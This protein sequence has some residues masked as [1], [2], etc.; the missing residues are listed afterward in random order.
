M[1]LE[2]GLQIWEALSR[3]GLEA[4]RKSCLPGYDVEL[5]RELKK[6]LYP[7]ATHSLDWELRNASP[8][9]E[10]FL[11]VFFS[12]LKPFSQML[13]DVLRMFEEAGARRSDE[14]LRIA[15]NF[16][17]ASKELALTL[18]E[19]REVEAFF[20]RITKPVVERLWDSNTLSLLTDDVLQVLKSF[21]LS[22][23]TY[24]TS[25]VR[26]RHVHQWIREN[27]RPNWLPFPGF[28]K[29]GDEE[30]DKRIGMAEGL[31]H[32][33]IEEILKLGK[34]YREFESR[35]LEM[36][37]DDRKRVKGDERADINDDEKPRRSFIHAAHDFWPN[38]F[39]E[40]VCL[41]IESVNDLVDK[42]KISA[43]RL[44]AGINTGFDR[45]PR[46]ERTLISI[47][48]DL[49]ELINLPIWKKRH[50]LYAVWVATRI[51]DALNDFSWE[52][53]PDGDT[54]RFPFAGVELATLRSNDGGT[55]IF[56]TEK[57][58]PLKDGRA[59]GR[60]HIQPD[61]RIMTIPSHRDESTSLVV[62][63]KQYR[64]WSRSNFG[65]ALDDYA[66]GCPNASVVLVNYGP[67]DPGILDLV[68]HSRRNRTFLL[69]NFKPKGEEALA[70]FRDMVRGAY[71]TLL[72][73]RIM[74]AV[75]LE[76]TWG[77]MFHDLDLHLFI[78][79]NGIDPDQHIGFG[80]T[81]GSLVELPWAKWAE[82]I[83]TSP[84]G[85]ERIIIDRWLD[86]DYEVM[87]HDYSETPNF[88]DGDVSV[89]V[90][91]GSGIKEYVFR[92]RGGI[93]AWWYV[94][95]IHGETGRMEEMNSIHTEC[96][97]A[98]S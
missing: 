40:H 25:Q 20:R 16:N 89:R 5:V 70:M 60:K 54:L 73:P 80:S 38:S 87:V 69:G 19:F 75:E 86:A 7:N 78:R 31:I 67:T 9:A 1:T 51:A 17:K 30:L 90:S 18:H 28:P 77:P 43:A 96:P 92:P 45:P 58:T 79:P 41:G 85:I 59:F 34:T 44:S 36:N 12:S 11:D 2:N 3:S 82:D 94:C 15:F 84:P 53:H 76:L 29:S 65:K 24:N 56:W 22:S 33:M 50:E 83:R 26:D 32:Y 55:H 93:G 37:S 52:W 62:E 10:T 61:Y 97:Y 14:N 35:L 4:V 91:M 21:G 8:T 88:P 81:Q 63:C 47:E 13:R 46:R 98:I 71:T 66:K 48:K 68:D 72:V 49:R 74:G 57:R 27:G 95:R 6:K 64:K 23:S 39:A 42:K